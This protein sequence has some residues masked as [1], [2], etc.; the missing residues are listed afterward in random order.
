M[1]GETA[2]PPAPSHGSSERQRIARTIAAVF[3]EVLEQTECGLDDPFFRLGG[4]SMAGLRVLTR[5][6]EEFGVGIQVADLYSHSTPLALADRLIEL[7]SRADTWR[8]SVASTA[9]RRRGKPLP[10]S[11][12]QEGFYAIEKV[13]RG[14]GIFNSVLLMRLTGDV[15]AAALS[16]AIGDVVQRQ[17]ALRVQFGEEAGRAG[18]RLVD[19]PP[20]ITRLDLRGRGEKALARLA[21]MEYL[22]G[23][24][25]STEPPARFTV[26]RMTDDGWALIVTVHHIAFDGMSQPILLDEL[27]HAY[28]CRVGEASPRPPLRADY[29]DFAEWQRDVLRGDRLESH[30][31]G[32]CEILRDP[33]PAIAPREADG[34][35]ASRIDDLLVPDRTARGMRQ[36]AADCDSTI[37]IV[38]LAALTDFAYRRTKAERQL[39]TV[40]TA[41]RNWPGSE[42]MVGCFS[43]MLCVEV[44]VDPLAPPAE[45]LARARTAMSRALRHEELPL[46]YALDLLSSRGRD[47]V[48]IGNM[49]QLGFTLQPVAEDRIDLP[50]CVMTAEAV[51][52][53]RENSDPTS[54]PL[55]VELGLTQQGLAGTTYRLLDMWPDDSFAQAEEELLAAFARFSV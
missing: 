45:A 43:N 34:N 20:V 35:F 31:E 49:P 47:L 8:R 32:L 21:K 51:Q 10:L 22:R 25:L 48:A 15:D 12:A 41:N 26:A 36:L 19:R 27:A 6:H 23:F 42:D 46:D 39:I 5:L 13:T 18:Q 50:G 29:L 24:D 16:D 38:L 53:G 52:Q 37:F 55:V 2:A 3:D 7:R 33:A 30:L 54:F 14:V 4:D 28:R 44:G 11:L 1:I 9:R 40:Q 17:T